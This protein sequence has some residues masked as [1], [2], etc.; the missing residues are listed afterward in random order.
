MVEPRPK[1]Q[2]KIF[3]KQGGKHPLVAKDMGHI[4]SMIFVPRASRNFLATLLDNGII[5]DKKEHRVSFDS[6][7]M[8]ELFQSNFCNLFEGP[9]VLSQESSEAGNRAMQKGMGKGLNHR[10]GVGFFAE[11]DKTSDK[12][13][14]N[15]ERRS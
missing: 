6:Q 10:G 13:R 15:F 1:G 5:D 8:K 2:K 7:G 9:N 3:I 14:E 12:G 11:L 4:L